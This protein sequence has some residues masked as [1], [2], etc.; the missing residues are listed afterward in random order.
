MAKKHPFKHTLVVELA[1]K[2]HDAM[3]GGG[4]KETQLWRQLWIAQKENL[5][6]WVEDEF[7]TNYG[8]GENMREWI[9]DD[10]SG[11]EEHFTEFMRK[12]SSSKSWNLFDYAGIEK[13]ISYDD[14]M[15]VKHTDE[16]LTFTVPGGETEILIIDWS[17]KPYIPV[18]D[19]DIQVDRSLEG[20]KFWTEDTYLP[21]IKRNARSA[22]ETQV[23]KTKGTQWRTKS[24]DHSRQKYVTIGLST[25]GVYKYL[26]NVKRGRSEIGEGWFNLKFK[27]LE[28]RHWEY[29]S[30]YS[31]VDGNWVIIW[32][33][34]P[35]VKFKVK[36]RDGT[37]SN[38]SVPELKGWMLATG[39]IQSMSFLNGKDE[40]EG[41][42]QGM[43][44]NI[45][46]SRI[47]NTKIRALQQGSNVGVDLVWRMMDGTLSSGPEAL[48]EYDNRLINGNITIPGEVSKR[49]WTIQDARLNA[50]DGNSY[51]E[52]VLAFLYA[53]Q[54]WGL[55]YMNRPVDL[56]SLLDRIYARCQAYPRIVERFMYC[57]YYFNP[58]MRYASINSEASTSEGRLFD[59]N[60]SAFATDFSIGDYNKVGSLLKLNTKKN[61][62]DHLFR[63]D[64]LAARGNYA[65]AGAR[66][67]LQEAIYIAMKKRI[68]NDVEIDTQA[69]LSCMRKAWYA[70]TVS[71]EE[72]GSDGKKYT[73]GPV[74]VWGHPSGVVGDWTGERD[75]IKYSGTAPDNDGFRNREGIKYDQN[76]FLVQ[77][78]KLAP[79]CRPAFLAAWRCKIVPKGP[80]MPAPDPIDIQPMEPG[81]Q[82]MNGVGVPA[83]DNDT[84]S[85]LDGAYLFTSMVT[86][87][88]GVSSPF[89]NHGSMAN[90]NA[91]AS[92]VKQ[93]NEPVRNAKTS[94]NPTNNMAKSHL[95]ASS[96]NTLSMESASAPASPGGGPIPDFNNKGDQ[97]L[98]SLTDTLGKNNLTDL[99][100]LL[101]E[102]GKKHPHLQKLI[103]S[104]IEAMM[105]GQFGLLLSVCKQ[106]LAL[107]IDDPLI[108]QIK[109]LCNS[110]IT[111]FYNTPE[112]PG[113]APS[114]VGNI[115][116]G[117]EAMAEAQLAD[118]EHLD[119]SNQE[120]CII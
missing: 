102:L 37:L 78:Y 33:N 11:D 105:N 25:A 35:A 112:S 114:T 79:D 97:M 8:D 50:G 13:S 103:M 63:F 7:Y 30:V 12:A 20:K 69:Y 15:P 80:P 74:K 70:G 59:E 34:I 41:V 115:K 44:N 96:G 106:I 104:A 58:L 48:S 14:A 93:L 67:P 55:L 85:W 113:M 36:N 66:V 101:L 72:E 22:W 4:T 32:V 29:E 1:E 57:F 118:N 53:K 46:S 54:A 116:K 43:Y 82:F 3:E 42:I 18:T 56:S 27:K 84:M 87:L 38:A 39:T 6:P 23:L 92:G 119:N 77:Q 86:D 61:W 47:K 9:L 64:I 76:P 40:P 31:S 73:I 90:L 83:Y 81:P 100:A 98:S 45:N 120:E 71:W 109:A 49:K 62:E 89:N 21:A 5:M 17:F 88:A 110:N 117:I 19:A 26:P 94:S 60:A 107:G 24:F 99:A 75:G 108:A 111:D 28:T 16:K 68:D 95:N 91:N 2:I 51:Q 52:H 65:W 10:F